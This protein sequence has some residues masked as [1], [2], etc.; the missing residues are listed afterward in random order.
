M[1][2][3]SL[4]TVFKIKECYTGIFEILWHSITMCWSTLFFLN[5]NCNRNRKEW[6]ICKNSSRLVLSLV[7]VMPRDPTTVRWKIYPLNLCLINLN[8]FL[9]ALFKNLR[10]NN[11][12]FERIWI[13]F[14]ISSFK[15]K[16]CKKT[17]TK[18][19]IICI[20][21][22][23]SRPYV[24]VLFNEQKRRSY[25]GAYSGICPGGAGLNFVLFPGRGSASVGAWKPHKIN[26]FHWSRGA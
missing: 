17:H 21:L 9:K 25:T 14:T 11:W 19:E 20:L 1:S 16:W 2:Y 26:R 15:Q 3:E 10:Q 13:L 6:W 12:K 23:S 18:W 5:R 8:V 22:N 4:S 7:D 24:E